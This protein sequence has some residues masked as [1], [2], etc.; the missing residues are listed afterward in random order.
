MLPNKFRF[1]WLS[2]FRREDF[3]EINQS[4]TRIANGGKPHDQMNPNLVGSISG[5]SSIKNA[6]FVPI[7]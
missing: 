3:L 4:E 1:I 7:H 6:H 2:G 5:R